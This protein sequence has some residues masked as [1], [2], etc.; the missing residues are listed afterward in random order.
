[1]ALVIHYSH[2]IQ[3]TASVDTNTSNDV[4]RAHRW[5]TQSNQLLR[6]SK[7]QTNFFIHYFYL[8]IQ[9]QINSIF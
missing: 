8:E 2:T 3:R 5:H 9:L 6:A 7:N 4:F 1:M